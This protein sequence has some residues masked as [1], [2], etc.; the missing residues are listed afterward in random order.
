[1][2][3]KNEIDGVYRKQIE[4]LTEQMMAYQRQLQGTTQ[5]GRVKDKIEHLTSLW[6]IQHNQLAGFNSQVQETIIAHNEAFLAQQKL[7]RKQFQSCAELDNI[8]RQ[9]IERVQSVQKEYQTC[10]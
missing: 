10:V 9:N 2:A 6:D 8:L 4:T 7:E 3:K 5:A 1:M